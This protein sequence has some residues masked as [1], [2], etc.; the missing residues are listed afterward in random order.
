MKIDFEIDGYRLCMHCST[1]RT[2]DN[3]FGSSDI[4]MGCEEEI[5][6]IED[7]QYEANL[8]RKNGELI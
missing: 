5:T 7:L 8:E 6:Q 1:F 2:Y 3:F 4:C